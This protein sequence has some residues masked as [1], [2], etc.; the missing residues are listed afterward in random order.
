MSKGAGVRRSRWVIGE[1][2][3]SLLG[4]VGGNKE[5]NE[6]V[7]TQTSGDGVSVGVCGWSEVGSVWVKV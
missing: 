3:R 5:R 6:S 1:A 4:R 7:E 2:V